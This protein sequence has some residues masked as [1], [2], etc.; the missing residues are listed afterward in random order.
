MKVWTVEIP[1]EED[2]E[3]DTTLRGV[4]ETQTRAMEELA[5]IYDNP[6]LYFTEEKLY[7]S[8]LIVIMAYQP[9]THS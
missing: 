4:Y 7:N 6:D 8:G 1:F 3:Y 5:K 2:F 9:T